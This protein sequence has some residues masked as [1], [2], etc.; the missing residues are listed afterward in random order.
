MGE[1]R[2]SGGEQGNVVQADVIENMTVT[3]SCG[4]R[5]DPPHDAT[6][7]PLAG[8]W[9]ALPAGAHRSRPGEDGSS[10][11]PY[12]ARDIDGRLRERVAA[13]ALRGGLV[14]VVGDSTAGKTRA[15]FEAVR[16]VLPEHRVWAPAVG[17]DVSHAPRSFAPTDVRYVVW[18]DDLERY[19]GPG[20]FQSAALVEFERLGIPVVATMRLKPFE[21]FN[22]Q[23]D[24]G[25]GARLLRVAEVVDLGRLWSGSEL[26]RAGDCD[27]SR[28]VDALT[29]HGP[30]G[31][32]EYLAAGPALLREWRRAG[33]GNGHARGAALVRAAV[34]LTRSGLRGP[35][36]RAL[37]AEVHRHYLSA[38]SVVPRPE[39][40]DAAFD[41]ASRVRHGVTSLLLP[42]DGEPLLGGECPPGEERWLAFDYLVDHTE[43]TESDIPD[44]VWQAA[45]AAA[46]AA[47]RLAIGRIALSVAPHIAESAWRPLADE[48]NPYAANDLAILLGGS[49]HAE[50]A[51]ALYR[52]AIAK[53]H[54]DAA[55]NLAVLLEKE[56]RTDEAEA[57]YRQALENGDPYAACNLADLLGRT[58]RLA[59]ALALYRRALKNGHLYAAN[60]LAMLLK[61]MGSLDDAVDV[62]RLA[63]SQ[64]DRKA[65]ENLSDLLTFLGRADEVEA[66][67]PTTS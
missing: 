41:W 28:I 31:I 36:S 39:S 49:D 61:K 11:P 40:L 8:E 25:T 63:V 33:P 60:D 13:A 62:F 51:E 4:H 21:A 57:L 32:A 64:G 45:L 50:S 18:L 22:A 37:L 43:H 9:E 16:A 55:N 10:V 20:G 46:P 5:P 7:W 27:D 15:A 67:R 23:H 44:Q 29:R 30:Y 66:V 2:V 34:D 42:V 38:E 17:H 19:L 47:D 58:G 3:P 26:A 65:A 52:R 12:I 35:Y 59:E 56:G 53:G 48:G 24:D 6:C 14:L 54:L 1:N